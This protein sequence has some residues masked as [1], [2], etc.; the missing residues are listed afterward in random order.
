M[1]FTDNQHRTVFHSAYDREAKNYDEVL[2]K[3]D[4]KGATKY[5]CVILLTQELKITLSE[6]NH[7]V[8]KSPVWEKSRASMNDVVGG[9]FD[10]CQDITD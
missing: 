10:F 3:L 6:A 7:I 1:S 2:A 9:F 8:H 4:E 5:D